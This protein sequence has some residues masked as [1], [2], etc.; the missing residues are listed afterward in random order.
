MI[1]PYDNIDFSNLLTNLSKTNSGRGQPLITRY[2][3]GDDNYIQVNNFIEHQRPHHTE[4]DSKIPPN[5]PV[6][7]GVLT[8]T[9]RIKKVGKEAVLGKG[10]LTKGAK[11]EKGVVGGKKRREYPA[12]FERLWKIHPKGGKDAGYRAMK[13]LSPEQ[14]EIDRWIEKLEAYKKTEQWQRG[15]S[16]NMSTWI[17]GGYFDGEV[18][19]LT[20]EEPPQDTFYEDLTEEDWEQ[21]RLA[22][23]QERKG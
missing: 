6:V 13:K 21:R 20:E 18:P 1:L 4:K 19:D 5:T 9:P 11:D 7:N 8:V 23:E 16:P 17:N 10:E 2:C 3:V 12:S 14:S 15:V 22:I